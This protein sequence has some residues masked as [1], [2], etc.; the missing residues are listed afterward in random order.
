MLEPAGLFVGLFS[1]K[2]QQLMEKIKQDHVAF[3]HD[4]SD[5]VAC[6]SQLNDTIMLVH[7]KVLFYQ[8]FD[9]RDHCRTL[10]AQGGG[11]IFNTCFLALLFEHKYGFNI[12]LACRCDTLH[13]YTKVRFD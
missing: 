6:V 7:D 3:L 9:C 12:I 13:F 11:N 5:L 2:P 4:L 10:D 1:I 8:R